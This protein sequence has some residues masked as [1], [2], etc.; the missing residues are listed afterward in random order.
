MFLSERQ[1][2]DQIGRHPNALYNRSYPP[3]SV[4]IGFRCGTDRRW[5]HP[6]VAGRRGNRDYLSTAQR[7]TCLA[8]P[9]TGAA[10]NRPIA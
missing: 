1:R 5:T 6:P 2:P 8:H 7:A 10:D 3:R 4:A 9:S